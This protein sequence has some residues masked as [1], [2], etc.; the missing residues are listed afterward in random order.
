MS[1]KVGSKPRSARAAR[2]LFPITIVVHPKGPT[3]ASSASMQQLWITKL[4]R[5][6]N[7][8]VYT[9]QEPYYLLT[10]PMSQFTVARRRLM[11]L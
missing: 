9:L 1:M 4:L 6:H 5:I 7:T 2:S 10:S 3:L 11:M 8:D